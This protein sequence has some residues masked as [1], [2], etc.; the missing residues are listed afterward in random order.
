MQKNSIAIFLLF[1]LLFDSHKSDSPLKV[2]IETF[3]TKRT[4]NSCLTKQ[5]RQ[6]DLT[7]KNEM[8]FFAD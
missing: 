7:D 6:N 3:A 8:P 4:I 1:L 2:C 5:E